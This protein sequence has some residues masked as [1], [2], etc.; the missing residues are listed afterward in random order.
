MIRE[1]YYNQRL[2][3]VLFLIAMILMA[4]HGVLDAGMDALT[5]HS[6]YFFPDK[7]K[8]WHMLKLFQ[9]MTIGGAFFFFA[10]SA[11]RIVDRKSVIWIGQLI[12]LSLCYF[13]FFEAFLRVLH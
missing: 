9:K 7:L 1:D 13:V 4:A 3:G 2:A 10:L 12:L 6:N 11:E 8:L 5:F